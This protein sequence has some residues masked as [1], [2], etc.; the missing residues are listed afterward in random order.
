[1]GIVAKAW[2]RSR[3]GLGWRQRLDG[4]LFAR[5][6][7]ARELCAAIASISRAGTGDIP[8]GRD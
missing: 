7:G 6:A 2:W 3:S 4:G 5:A 8:D 1:M